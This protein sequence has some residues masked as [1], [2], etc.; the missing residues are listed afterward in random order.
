MTNIL[1]WLALGTITGTLAYLIDPDEVAG[2]LGDSLTLGI[3]GSV[4]GGIMGNLL[5]GVSITGF[6]LSSLT[7]AVI[8]SLLTV[9]LQRAFLRKL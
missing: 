7:I 8:G 6:N 1:F 3:L 9:M 5:L 4:M 2:G